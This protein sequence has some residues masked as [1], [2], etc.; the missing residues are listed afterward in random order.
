MLNYDLRLATKHDIAALRNIEQQ[1]F[2]IDDFSSRNFRYLLTKANAYTLVAACED[3]LLGYIMLL[4]RRGTKVARI[5]SIAVLL[6]GQGIAARLLQAAEQQA[7]IQNCQL[8]YLEIRQ[9]NLASQ[10][11]FQRHGYNYFASYEAYY[12]DKQLALRFKKHL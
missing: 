12:S 4:F 7:L 10:S 2:S 9:D 8:I 6:K 3:E 11:F 1:C 5:Y